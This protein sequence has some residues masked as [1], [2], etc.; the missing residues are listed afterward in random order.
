VLSVKKTAEVGCGSEV[1]RKRCRKRGSGV[2]RT[3]V[4]PYKYYILW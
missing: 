2:R 1:D 3:G 4:S